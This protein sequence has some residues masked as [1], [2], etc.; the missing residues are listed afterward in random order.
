MKTTSLCI[1]LFQN[2]YSQVLGLRSPYGLSYGSAGLGGFDVS[3][4]EVNSNRLG[5]GYGGSGLSPAAR[6]RNVGVG[7]GAAGLSGVNA[8]GLGSFGNNLVE[9][10]SVFNSY[11]SL[12][13]SGALPT[14][15][16]GP[17]YPAGLS[18]LSD[19][20][21]ESPVVVNGVLPYL[22]AVAVEG[23]YP[24]GGSGVAQCGCGN[25]NVG[26]VSE[27]VR[28]VTGLAGASLSGVG[29]A[30][31]GLANAGLAGAGLAGAGLANANV[32]GVS[33]GGLGLGGYGGRGLIL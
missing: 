5:A 20:A 7:L 16:I 27:T 1:F 4:Y 29:L 3:A 25:G 32:A 10:S 28:P 21:F 31:A 30:G 2:V 24:S 19:N 33:L 23:A 15:S 26:I 8:L 17:V 22:S 9:S 12:S 6:L 18:V 14:S 11:N 13:G